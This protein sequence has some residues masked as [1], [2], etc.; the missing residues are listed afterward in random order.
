MFEARIENSRGQALTL[1]QKE[2][3]YQVLN[4]QG[5]NPTPGQV[6]MTSV[7]GIDGG[8]FNSSKLATKELTITIKLNGEIERNRLLL[9]EYFPTKEAVRFFFRNDTRDVFID[10]Y[11]ETVE[12]DPFSRGERMQVA[13]ICPSAYFKSTEESVDPVTKELALF[14]FPFYIDEGDPVPFSEYDSSRITEIR[15]DSES[16]TGLQI[17]IAFT[18]SVNAVKIQNTVTGEE[19]KLAYSFQA[20]DVVRINTNNGQKSLKLTRNGTTTN[21][22]P[23][24]QKGSVFLRLRPGNNYFTFEA[25]AGSSDEKLAITFRHFTVY[26]GV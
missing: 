14:E 18:G 23:A 17:E 8:R 11:V 21:L 9:Y 10:G 13:I 26:R 15:N 22:F 7:A 6:N 5:L 4:I 12:V 1:T 2:Q 20:D 16:E 24:L 19:L 25:D 3:E